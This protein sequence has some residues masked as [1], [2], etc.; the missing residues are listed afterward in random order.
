MT[1]EEILDD[2]PDLTSEDIRACLAFAADRERRL[3]VV[4]AA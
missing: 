2:F 1:N 3:R 4:P